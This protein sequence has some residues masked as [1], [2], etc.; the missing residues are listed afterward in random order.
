MTN[1]FSSISHV[2]IV[3]L[4]MRIV[5]LAV[6]VIFCPSVIFDSADSGCEHYSGQLVSGKVGS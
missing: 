3:R 5:I 6:F 4:K 2:R 1:A